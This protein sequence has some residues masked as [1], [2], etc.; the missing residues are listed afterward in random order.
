MKHPIKPVNGKILLEI[1]ELVKQS[2]IHRNKPQTK[3]QFRILAISKDTTINNITDEYKIGDLVIYDKSKGQGR[4][5]NNGKY[6]LV[7]PE[8]IFGVVED[9]K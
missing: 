3:T 1:E 7:A 6:V 2:L 8:H 9:L 4:E 5:L